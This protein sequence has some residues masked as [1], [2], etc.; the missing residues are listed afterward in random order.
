MFMMSFTQIEAYNSSWIE[1]SD[2]NPF[3]IQDIEI[4]FTERNSSG[5]FIGNVT[6]LQH[7]HQMTNGYVV[8]NLDDPNYDFTTMLDDGYYKLSPQPESSY[9]YVY[10][11][12]LE[13]NNHD[14]TYHFELVW[15]TSS[16]LYIYWVSTDDPAYEDSSGNDVDVNVKLF[17]ASQQ[18]ITAFKSNYLVNY[19]SYDEGYEDGRQEGYIEGATVYGYIDENGD[20]YSAASWGLQEYQRGLSQGA[21]DTL[22]LQ[23]MIPGVL[24]VFIAFFFQVMSISVLGVSILDIIALMFGVAVVLL[25]FKTFIK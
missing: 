14:Y 25:L 2:V 20:Y 5:S 9:N 8:F 7:W 11:F 22:S 21:G 19:E 18:Y 24:G 23:N 3:Y 15:T 13:F 12:G 4:D 6:S 17:N 1:D 10:M 16:E